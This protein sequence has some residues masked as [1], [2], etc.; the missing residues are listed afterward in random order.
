MYDLHSLQARDLTKK[1]C[2]CHNKCILVFCSI[3]C[4]KVPGMLFT[5]ICPHSL[6]FRPL[7][8][9]DTGKQT[10]IDNHQK[11]LWLKMK[12]FH[13]FRTCI[14]CYCQRFCFPLHLTYKSLSPTFS[15]DSFIDIQIQSPYKSRCSVVP[16]MRHA[17]A[18]LMARSVCN[19]VKVI[20]LSLRL[21]GHRYQSYVTR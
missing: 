14:C 11:V 3:L 16:G 19:W 4:G 5:P 15:R 8:F 18:P 21:L 13:Y 10:L 6:S 2:I 12:K 9:P 7:V 17:G 1:K 20:V